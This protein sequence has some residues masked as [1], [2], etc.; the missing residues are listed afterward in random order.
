MYFTKQFYLFTILRATFLLATAQVIGDV[1][2][3]DVMSWPHRDWKMCFLKQDVAGMRTSKILSDVVI[4][5]WGVLQ[6]AGAYSWRCEVKWGGTFP[7]PGNDI[8]SGGT[9]YQRIMGIFHWS[10]H[11]HRQRLRR[12]GF[13]SAG[14]WSMQMQPLESQTGQI[15]ETEHVCICASECVCLC[16]NRTHSSLWDLVSVKPLFPLKHT[17]PLWCLLRADHLFIWSGV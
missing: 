16:I 12:G 8:E 1:G 15:M 17:I 9:L 7:N 6:R 14:G 10:C 3:G 11:W 13:G 4:M 2:G 5:T